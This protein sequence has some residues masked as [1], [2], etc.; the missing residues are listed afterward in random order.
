M[1]S[2]GGPPSLTDQPSVPNPH[3][4]TNF[5]ENSSQSSPSECQS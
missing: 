3:K 4:T 2:P 5:Y 1:A